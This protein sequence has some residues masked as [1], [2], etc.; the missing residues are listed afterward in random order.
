[1]ALEKPLS[2]PG[3]TYYHFS[4]RVSLTFQEPQ[5]S[6][7]AAGIIAAFENHYSSS[8]LDLFGLLSGSAPSLLCPHFS[9]LCKLL[10]L[11]G[12]STSPMMGSVAGEL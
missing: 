10:S 12:G 8:C 2:L 1:M 7:L 6:W 3:L 9:A 11:Q 4:D 5:S